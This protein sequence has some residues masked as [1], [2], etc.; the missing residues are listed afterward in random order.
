MKKLIKSNQHIW[1]DQV[2][3]LPLLKIT[4]SQANEL[5]WV[6]NLA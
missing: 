5:D 3:K 2:T 4:D 1:A 6:I